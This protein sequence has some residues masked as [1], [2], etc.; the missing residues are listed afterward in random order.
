MSTQTL[1]TAVTELMNRAKDDLRTLV[2]LPSI[3]LDSSKAQA[4][5]AS[6]D[7]VAAAFA[8]LGFS[9]EVIVTCDGSPAIV[10][11]RPGPEGSPTIALYSHHDVQPPGPDAEWNTPPF[12]LTDHDGRWYGRGAADCKGN[13]VAHLTAL[14]AVLD[15]VSCNVRII[16]EGSEEAGGEG[17]DDLVA[18]RPELFAADLILI[19][20]T[21]NV[22]VGIPTLT[23]SLRG[24]VNVK[25]T[26]RALES[27]VHAGGAG[28]PT[29]D[30]MAALI[31]GIASLRNEHGDTVIEG[32]PND[33]KWAG[34]TYSDEQF[35]KDIGALDGTEIL[36]S[37]DPADM[38]WARPVVTVIGMDVP[39]TEDC[40]AAIIPQASAM[41][42]L[43]VPPGLDTEA[44]YH[45][46]VA[47]LREHTPW[48]VQMEFEPDAFGG[49]FRAETDGPGYTALTE[50]MVSAYDGVP[51]FHAGQGGSIPLTSALAAAHPD[52]EIALLGVEEPLTHIHAP[53]ESVDPEELRRTALAEAIL[54][55]TFGK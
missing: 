30:A 42:N 54:L 51:V 36:G 20:D 8:E 39:N 6:A 45:A 9:S 31:A 15:D 52:A 35:R 34:V 29:P 33:Q 37:G 1:S 28:G 40:A 32:V 2:S 44:T 27:G 21:G 23:T 38:A 47:H 4:N 11:H 13:I 48:G 19:G 12:E 24:V 17:L 10:G 16:I 41:L 22:A 49:G 43:R 18:R 7:W 50:A 55:T 53:N 3:H 46:L 26:V 5:R 25:M 14:R